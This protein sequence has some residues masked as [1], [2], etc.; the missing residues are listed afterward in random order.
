M[1]LED[2][3]V[4]S[5]SYMFNDDYNV[6]KKPGV[7]SVDDTLKGISEAGFRFVELLATS[8]DLT[9]ITPKL[10]E[11]NNE[12]AE[13]LKKK[14]KRYNLR[15]SGIYYYQGQ[16]NLFID[17]SGLKIFKIIDGCCLLSSKFLITDMDFINNEKKWG[18]FYKNI[19]GVL[20]YAAI[21][22]I[23]I[24]FDIH[25]QWCCNGKN[26]AYIINKV[27]HPNLKINYCTGNAIYWGNSKPEDD[28]DY[29]LPFL[30]RVHLKDSTG[31]PRDYDFPALGEGIINFENILFKL[32]DFK[33]P[34]SIEV[35]LD[36]KNNSLKEINTAML[37]SRDFLKDII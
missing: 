13:K 16:E 11:M 10:C 36:G 5:N 35:E 30:G 32:K 15:L 23:I 31:R 34:V 12:S 29:A 9:H 3:G 14:L 6:E 21:K 25:G 24:C 8:G 19:G 22:G 27:G 20:E 26:A 1:E 18:L 2:F 28:I 37:R 7:Y 4:F 17:S 33:G